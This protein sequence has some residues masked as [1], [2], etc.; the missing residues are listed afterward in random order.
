MGPA[1]LAG[2]AVEGTADT[3][4]VSAAATVGSGTAVSAG[5]AV[6]PIG[7]SSAVTESTT[8]TS[9][10]KRKDDSKNNSFDDDDEDDDEDEENSPHGAQTT[11]LG[12][13]VAQA[14]PKAKVMVGGK[15]VHRFG[16][17]SDGDDGDDDDDDENEQSNEDNAGEGQ[18]KG[19]I[20]AIVVVVDC[21]LLLVLVYQH[22]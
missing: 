20:A 12:P 11:A 9:A 5:K 8:V 13:V 4:A 14:G 18:K 17:G 16:Q 15:R 1:G 22:L 7:T 21:Y 10:S 2:L 19:L 6:T 3:A